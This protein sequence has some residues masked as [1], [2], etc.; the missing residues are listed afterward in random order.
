M[1]P[2]LPRAFLERPI[3]HRALHDGTGRCPENSLNAIRAA[4]AA[5][6]GVEVDIQL[7]ADGQAM[8]F[9]D[10]GLQRL[11]GQSGLVRDATSKDLGQMTLL[12]GTATVPTLAQCLTAVAGLVPVLIEL[13]DQDGAL[14]PEVGALEQAVARDLAS[15]DGPVAVMSFNPHSTAAM[16][17]LAPAVCRGLTTCAFT[18]DEY[19]D[20]PAD[21]RKSLS[22]IADFDRVGASFVSHDRTDLSNPALTAL[23]SRNAPVLCWT[24]RSKAEEKAA[25]TVAHQITFEGY[26]PA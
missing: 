5:G 25:R 13:K 11:T 7:S 1:T 26:D 4:C 12:G 9:H 10:Y 8:V 20:V 22:R 23:K 19:N 14:G 3:A 18:G 2:P 17:D 24:V 15:Y 21:R 6:Y 16:Q